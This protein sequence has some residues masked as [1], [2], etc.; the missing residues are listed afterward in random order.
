MTE[1]EGKTSAS[2][3]EE[4]N[5]KAPLISQHQSLGQYIISVIHGKDTLHPQLSRVN[6][7]R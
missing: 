4:Q 3:L 6:P 1:K 5:I 7:L 2:K